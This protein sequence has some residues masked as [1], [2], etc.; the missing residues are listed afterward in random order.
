MENSVSVI[1]AATVAF[2][3]AILSG[4]GVGSGGLFVIWLVSAYGISAPQARGMN[5]L[6]F[7]FSASAALL[8][9]IFKGKIDPSFVA[10][11]ALCALVGTIFGTFVARQVDALLLRKIFGIFLVLSGAYSLFNK[12]IFKKKVSGNKTAQLYGAKDQK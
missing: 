8:I 1:I 12:R 5:L 7:V 6:F 2:F 9:H 4:L 10:K 3:I 11:L